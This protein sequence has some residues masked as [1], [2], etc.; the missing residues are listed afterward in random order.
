MDKK[1]LGNL[2]AASADIDSNYNVLKL[3][4]AMMDQAAE[5]LED[6]DLHVALIN[7]FNNNESDTKRT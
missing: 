3:A 4:E 1:D 6:Y 7:A 5:I 2:Q